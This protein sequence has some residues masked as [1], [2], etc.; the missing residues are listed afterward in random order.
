MPAK[1]RKRLVV[2][3]RYESSLN[4]LGSIKARFW[5]GTTLIR[6]TLRE[7]MKPANAIKPMTL[8]AHVNP[9]RG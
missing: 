8:V 9:T 6:M 2:K 3:S 7:T 4:A 1:D 5:L